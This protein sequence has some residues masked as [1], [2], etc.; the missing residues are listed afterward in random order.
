MRLRYTA[1]SANLTGDIFT[2]FFFIDTPNVINPTNVE[3]DWAIAIDA[4][5]VL[6]PLREKTLTI[7][8]LAT[9]Q[10]TFFDLLPEQEQDVLIVIN[11]NNQETIFRGYALAD[12]FTQ[13]F[14]RDKWITTIKATDGLNLLSNYDYVPFENEVSLIKILDKAL[15]RTGHNLSIAI[16]KPTTSFSQTEPKSL[17]D[18]EFDLYQ[19]YFNCK[20][21]DRNFEDKTSLEVIEEILQLANCYIIQGHL[22]WYILRVPG[23]CRNY[24]S[25][26]DIHFEVYAD[27]EFSRTESRTIKENIGSQINNPNWFWVNE[28]Q[29]IEGRPS[30]GA[31]KAVYDFGQTKEKILNYHLINDGS[32]MDDWLIFETD[33]D[34]FEFENETSVSIKVP[35]GTVI[36]KDKSF[37]GIARDLFKGDSIEVY[38]R[39][40]IVSKYTNLA[41]RFWLFDTPLGKNYYLNDDGETWNDGTSNIYQFKTGPNF[42]VTAETTI[43][44]PPLPEDGDMWIEI[45]PPFFTN[46]DYFNAFNNFQRELIIDEIRVRPIDGSGARGIEVGSQR[47]TKPSSVIEENK[48]FTIGD[49]EIT[50][51]DYLGTLLDSQGNV[52]TGDWTNE[53]T[54]LRRGIFARYTEDR[55]MV[56][57][58]SRLVFTG[59]VYGYFPYISFVRIDTLEGRNFK[60]VSWEHNL[61]NNTTNLTLHEVNQELIYTDINT[62]TEV[63]FEESQNAKISN[64]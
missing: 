51:L 63:K 33:T 25:N 11:K 13:D 55:L 23:F 17:I 32:L 26:N 27:G 2:L 36:P 50:E 57:G 35:F 18:S 45:Y 28:N 46:Y 48:T 41:V 29:N 9:S 22:S 49:S 58:K 20:V 30:L 16:S 31:N 47:I 62:E 44:L 34:Y 54:Q 10:Q 6:A 53:N 1:Q 24:W 64:L 60:V 56:K 19:S 21:H 39:Y 40:Y 38:F 3:C 8:L 7:N 52:I 12:G 37:A 43:T 14:T 5:D 4:D 61:T 15:K 59:D 42:R